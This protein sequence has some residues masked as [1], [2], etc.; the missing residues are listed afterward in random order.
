MTQPSYTAQE[1]CIVTSECVGPFKNG[2]IGTSMTG[3]AETLAHHGHKVVLLYTRG[4]YLTSKQVAH[5]REVYA[6]N[7]VDFRAVRPSD[8]R[9]YAGPLVSLGY[10]TPSFIVDFLTGTQFD[11]VHFN[12]T[13]GEGFLAHALHRAGLLLPHATFQTNIHSP[14]EWVGALNGESL[15]HPIDLPMRSAERFSIANSDL[16]C[17]PSQ[18]LLD[19]I[20]ERGYALPDRIVQQQYVMPRDVVRRFEAMAEK[21]DNNPKAV[22]RIV[23]FGRLEERKGLRLFLEAIS[24]VEQDLARRNV[25]I[26]FLGRSVTIGGKTSRDFIADASKP[27]AVVHE[28][29]TDKGQQEALDYLSEPGT[30][31]VI[32]SPADN[33]PCT[34][35]ECLL[36]QL[37]FIAAKT[38]GIPELIATEFHEKVLF[39]HNVEDLK[40]RINS[41]LAGETVIPFP[42]VSQ[43]DNATR[44]LDLHESFRQTKDTN[45]KPNADLEDLLVFVDATLGR[46]GEEVTA[47][48][49]LSAGVSANNIAVLK[50][51]QSVAGAFDCIDA[52]GMTKRL[53]SHDGPVLVVGAGLSLSS[54]S[55]LRKVISTAFHAPC[56]GFLLSCTVENGK[57]L[58]HPGY[59]AA[60]ALCHGPSVAHC[61]LFASGVSAARRFDPLFS[62]VGPAFGLIDQTVVKGGDMWPLAMPV[63]RLS[64]GAT[65]QSYIPMTDNRLA[66]YAGLPHYEQSALLVQAAVAAKINP[67]MLARNLVFR[68][69]TTRIGGVLPYISMLREKTGL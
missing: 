6:Q 28:V 12:D 2:G 38:G 34:V 36:A 9:K 31:T 47:K 67:K 68:L 64:E 62:D 26:T 43:Q 44:W 40:N 33:S 65:V 60:V 8:L 3:L 56:D 50:P 54:S 1:I 22:Q 66:L 27:W 19:W 7:G 42:A 11:V 58:D 17:G 52:V 13:D 35:Y 55:V 24:E 18:Y 53:A 63:A 49:V 32:A 57:R 29:I 5:W 15:L 48:S 25:S 14:R 37:P 41:H 10:L 4:A 39:E 45:P 21:R 69:A 16:I 30:L 20:E 51:N 46:G 23:F 61:T 59:G